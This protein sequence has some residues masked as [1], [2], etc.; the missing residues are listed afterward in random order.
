MYEY[1]Q[2][3]IAE[4]SPAHLVLD[5]NGVGYMV[6]ISLQTYTVLSQKAQ[7]VVF[8]HQIVREDAHLLYGFAEKQEREMFRL[9]LSVSGI[10]ANTARMI[11]SSLSYADT[12]RAIVEGNVNLL[13]SIKGIGLKTAQRVIIDLKDKVG[14]AGGESIPGSGS[15]TNMDE[16]LAALVMLGFSKQPSEKVLGSIVHENNN[17]SVEELIK[18]A[19]KR[20]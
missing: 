9:L 4:I 8:I 20:L 16:A 6:H 2:G 11:L 1:I 7:A 18:L 10:G 19:L 12:T 17:I 5:C 14:R 15:H 3:K 13:K